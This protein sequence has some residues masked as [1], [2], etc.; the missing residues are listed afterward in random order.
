MA[1]VTR[2]IEF[3][4]RWA[5]KS[6]IIQAPMAGGIT[7][8]ELVSA[9]CNAGG[10]GSLATG[11]LEAAAVA[12]SLAQIQTLTDR[13]YA[14]NLF[15]PEENTTTMSAS[16]LEGFLTKLN[17]YRHELQLEPLDSKDLPKAPADNFDELVELLLKA[18]VP[19]VSFTFGNLPSDFI[20]AFHDAGTYLMGTAN[21]LEEALA[22]QESG[23]DAVVA[24]GF[25]AGGHRG[26][27]ITPF[28][29]AQQST[30]TLL[31]LM[32]DNLRIPVIAAGGLMDGRS[33]AKTL[34][35]GAAAVQLGTAFLCTNESGLADSA[36]LALSMA[37]GDSVTAVTTAYSGK[38]AR[39][40]DNRFMQEMLGIGVLPPYPQA[41]YLTTSTRKEAAQQGKQDLMAVWCGK[42]VSDIRRDLSATALLEQLQRECEASLREP[43]R[44]NI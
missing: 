12:D 44:L 38:P 22:L 10:M 31:S 20:K 17:A 5:I 13:P 18:K 15:V 29:Q 23:I 42:G 27:F 41:H 43:P 21:S 25:E 40:L 26:G 39:G 11:Y 9:V 7:T 16:A 35:S 36:K 30:H 8:P 3:A 19:C 33:I 4:R 1:G 28:Y 14:V 32:I 34:T 37:E 6:P 2:S 24:Q